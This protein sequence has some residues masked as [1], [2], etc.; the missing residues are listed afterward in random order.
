VLHFIW[1]STGDQLATGDSR[2][3]E[4]SAV[5]DIGSCQEIVLC[6]QIGRGILI[7]T[8]LPKIFLHAHSS[9]DLRSP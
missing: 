7:M 8:Y 5:N 2:V 1:R 6:A 4:R 3:N 9:G